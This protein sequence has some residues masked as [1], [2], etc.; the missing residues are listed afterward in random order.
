MAVSGF[1]GTLEY[2]YLKQVLAPSTSGVTIADDTL[3]AKHADFVFNEANYRVQV[4]AL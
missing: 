3:T 1:Y 2:K 4:K